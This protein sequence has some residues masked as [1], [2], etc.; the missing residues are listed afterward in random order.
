MSDT[1]VIVRKA[2][3]MADILRLAASNG[4]PMPC[5]ATVDELRASLWFRTL[6]DLTD[7]ALWMDASIGDTAISDG[8]RVHHQAVGRVLDQHVA[9]WTITPSV[10]E[11][12]LR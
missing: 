4:L 8:E 11:R 6:A 1:P 5:D 9:V 2:S 10:S 7:W 12:A 3:G